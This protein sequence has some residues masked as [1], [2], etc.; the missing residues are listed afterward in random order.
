MGVAAVEALIDPSNANAEA[1]LIG[2]R[3]QNV[4][5]TH[6]GMALSKVFREQTQ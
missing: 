3:G 5:K 6:L 4:F 1:Y 2:V